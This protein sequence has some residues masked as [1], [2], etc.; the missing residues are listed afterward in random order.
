M[1]KFRYKPDRTD[2]KRLTQKIRV[3]VAP[4]KMFGSDRIIDMGPNETTA[5]WAGARPNRP[6]TGYAPDQTDQIQGMGHTEYTIFS[7]RPEGT[8]RRRGVAGHNRPN[9][10][11]DGHY[12]PTLDY[13]PEVTD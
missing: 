1:S 4:E 7:C 13:G 9:C 6:K 10:G 5:N 3:R 12:R 8:D 2:T 11:M